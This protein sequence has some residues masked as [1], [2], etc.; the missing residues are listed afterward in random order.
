MSSSSSV[1]ATIVQVVCDVVV[2][3][4][5]VTRRVVC[6][7]REVQCLKS[8]WW[9]CNMYIVCSVHS[10]SGP[11]LSFMIGFHAS[12]S[13]WLLVVGR[14]PAVVWGG[15]SGAPDGGGAIE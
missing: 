14:L 12:V 9:V 1:V 13:P 10:V 5:C 4:V 6:P 2:A 11:F 15:T 7:P 8:L 3:E